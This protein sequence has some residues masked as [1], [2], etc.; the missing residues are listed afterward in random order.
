MMNIFI[1]LREPFLDKIPSLKNL[2]WYLSKNGNSITIMSSCETKYPSLSFINPNIRVV[3]VK[4]RCRKLEP[5]TSLKLILKFIKNYILQRPAF[6]IGGDTYSNLLLGF[7]KNIFGYKHI[8]FLLE[9]PQIVTNS[10]LQLSNIEKLEIKTIK[11]AHF[12]ITHDDYHKRFLLDNFKIAEP[13]VSTLPNATFTEIEKYTSDFLQQRLGI[14]SNKKI[15]LHSGGLGVWFKCKELAE[16]TKDWPAN[17]LLVFHTSYDVSNEPYY[18]E[19]ISNDYFGKVLFSIKPVSTFELDSLICSANI[20]IALYSLKHLE[21][22]AELLG[23]AAGKIGN[24]LK[25][26]LPVIA[27]RLISFSY[28]VD[29]QCGILIDNESEIVNAIEYIHKNYNEYS[30]NAIICYEKLWEPTQYLESIIRKMTS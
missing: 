9:Y 15:I 13:N 7:F 12:I 18:R 19:I 25:C 6:C 21:Y 1:L 27:T 5:P 23:L 4:K 17:T 29:Y 30:K 2:I 26:G 10:H 28:L 20:G 16:S 22:R 3:Y 11:N 14:P 8:Y 24:Y